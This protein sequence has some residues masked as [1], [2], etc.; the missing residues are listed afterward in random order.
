VSEVSCA[1]DLA[2]Q[3][4]Q[5]LM[6]ELPLRSFDAVLPPGATAPSAGRAHARAFARECDRFS[7]QTAETGEL[8]VSELVTNAYEA[9][10]CTVPGTPGTCSQPAVRLSMRCFPGELLIEVI[11]R[12]PEPPVLSSPGRGSEHGR[13]LLLIEAL[14]RE[15]GWFPVPGGGKCVYCRLATET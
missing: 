2:T 4:R 9:A 14:S 11:D 5:P 3:R 1:L 10:C 13:G 6:P 8:L 12:S 7:A 15:W